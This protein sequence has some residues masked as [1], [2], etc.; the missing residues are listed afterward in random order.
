M[1]IILYLLLMSFPI[2]YYI[3]LRSEEKKLSNIT[4][5]PDLSGFEIANKIVDENVYIIEVRD[6]ALNTY[7]SNRET[8]KFSTKVFHSSD[9]L[10]SF[11]AAKHAFSTKKKSFLTGTL[12]NILDILNIASFIIFLVGILYDTNLIAI[13][14]SLTICSLGITILDMIS[15]KEVSK[16]AY[17][18]LVKNKI[19]D[20]KYEY[21]SEIV[22][23]EY[24]ARVFSIILDSI[25]KLI[26]TVFK[27]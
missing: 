25:N 16:Q 21:L 2:I 6:T 18:Y 11:L 9:I 23:Y 7:Y 22:K 10:S 19:I 27:S 5:K 1:I 8:L 3:R 15:N 24:V 12:L 17:N 26:K 20:K 13:S 4:N 14:I